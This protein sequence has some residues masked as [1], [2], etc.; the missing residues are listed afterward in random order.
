[1]DLNFTELPDQE[2][3]VMRTLDTTADVPFATVLRKTS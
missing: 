1:M 3:G 2:R